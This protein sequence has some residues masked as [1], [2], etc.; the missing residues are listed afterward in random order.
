MTIQLETISLGKTDVRITP[1][2][3]GVWQWGDTMMWGYGQS[4]GDADLRPV[5]DATLA[6]GIN[7]CDTFQFG[8][9]SDRFEPGRVQRS[10]HIR[11]KEIG[12]IGLFQISAGRESFT[13][14]G[15]QQRSLAL[16]PDRFDEDEVTP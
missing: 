7:S 15:H 14:G 2:G 9:S 4:Y 10:F 16:K 12:R 11:S 6:A 5:Y 3:L 1:L 8:F 13:E